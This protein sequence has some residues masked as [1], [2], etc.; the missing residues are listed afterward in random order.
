MNRDLLDIL[1]DSAS[2]EQFELRDPIYENERVKSGYL[3]SASSDSE[4]EI[5]DFI[6]RFVSDQKY[7]TSFGYEWHFFKKTQLDSHTGTHISRDRWSD[8]TG[9]QPE[10]MKGKVVLEAGC[11][12][13]RFLEIVAPFS[14]KCIGLDMSSAVDAASDNLIRDFSTV[15]IIQADLNRT[16]IQKNS[17]DFVYSIGVLDHIPDTLKGIKSLV[18]LIK[19]GGELAV[20]LYG[21]HLKIWPGDMYRFI[22]SRMDPHRLLTIL[23]KYVPFALKTHKIPFLGKFFKWVLFPAPE[24]A[25]LPIPED[26]RLEWSIL[27]AYDRF[28]SIIE[29]H[30][31]EEQLRKILQDAG[32]IN[33]RKNKVLNSFIGQKP[34]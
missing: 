34:A 15:D 29:K 2:N 4:Y 21:P 32:L 24:Y 9:Y 20:W 19:P 12:S 23:K 25:H 6:P 14:K 17:V 27:D 10:D 30:F 13:G 7:A 31:S 8:I 16:A 22:G 18:S 33:I 28:G 26:M 3:V 5:K 11:G 1:S